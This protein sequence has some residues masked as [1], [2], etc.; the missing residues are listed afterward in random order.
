[1]TT[2]N[3]ITPVPPTGKRFLSVKEAA[4]YLG[5]S[6]NT[7]YS[8]NCQGIHLPVIKFGR[9]V[10]IDAND[11]EAFIQ[12]NKHQPAEDRSHGRLQ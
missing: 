7:L 4:Q 1:M 11:L 10:V 12:D 9:R 3:N 2:T 5:L 8:W 6:P